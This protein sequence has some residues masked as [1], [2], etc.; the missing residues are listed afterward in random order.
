M[1][2]FVCM[3]TLAGLFTA[4]GCERKPADQTP[5]KVTEV[6]HS[7]GEAWKD[8]RKGAQSAWDEVDKAFRDA[9]KE[10]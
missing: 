8:V 3:L 5:E 6:G 4:I 1:L 7:T 2:R 9:A 10:F